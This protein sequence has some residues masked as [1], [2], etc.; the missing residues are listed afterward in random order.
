MAYVSLVIGAL[1]NAGI[2]TLVLNA[3]SAGALSAEVGEVAAQSHDV[4]I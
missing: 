2:A 3:G 4:S 1:V